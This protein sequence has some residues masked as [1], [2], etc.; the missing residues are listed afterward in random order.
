MRNNHY[1]KIVSFLEKC[2]NIK[3]EQIEESYFVRAKA[4]YYRRKKKP[5]AIETEKTFKPEAPKK[6][7]RLE[8]EPDITPI[9]NNRTNR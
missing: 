3:R 6:T 1:C 2:C 4:V 8:T 9:N 5:A 7:L